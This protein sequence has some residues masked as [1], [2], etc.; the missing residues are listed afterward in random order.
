[1]IH[2]TKDKPCDYEKYIN[3]D[4]A[5]VSFL[6]N[7]ERY[8]YFKNTANPMLIISNTIVFMLIMNLIYI[9]FY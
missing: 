7:Y 5:T 8:Q 6:N 3:T 2:G 1:M 9:F 4:Q